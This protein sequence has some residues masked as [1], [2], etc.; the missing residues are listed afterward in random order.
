MLMFKMVN[1]LISKYIDKGL[2]GSGLEYNGL[3]IRIINSGSLGF[4]TEHC[5]RTFLLRV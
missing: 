2:E 1:K 3:P 5:H 4:E